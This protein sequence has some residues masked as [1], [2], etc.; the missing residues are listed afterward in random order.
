MRIVHIGGSQTFIIG[1][2]FLIILALTLGWMIQA[3][4]LKPIK[5]VLM[6]IAVVLSPPILL[7]G[8]RG[9]FDSLIVGLMFLTIWF[10]NRDMPIFGLF[11]VFIAT[12]FKYYTLPLILIIGITNKRLRV[13]IFSGVLLILAVVS[14]YVDLAITEF[15]FTPNSPSLTFG[16]GHEFLFFE[17][18]SS[19]KWLGENSSELGLVLIGSIAVISYLLLPKIIPFENQ[20]T[21]NKD[22]SRVYF[23]S[24][25]LIITCYFSGFNADY[26]L[27]YFVFSAL[28]LSQIFTEVESLKQTVY[29]FITVILWLTFPSGDLE[30]L[31]DFALS[32][33]I[34]LN[35]ALI[36]RIYRIGRLKAL[37]Q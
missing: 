32:L 6:T 2:S 15:D 8:D 22:I 31:G 13:R 7:L 30:I 14:I 19:L 4:N 9:N 35:I 28:A 11:T 10:L 33:Y 3:L 29:V 12:I 17:N 5:N 25:T 18:F 34:G 37:T 1:I 24:T 36:A 26:R 27:I 20:P 16:I 23:F 21:F